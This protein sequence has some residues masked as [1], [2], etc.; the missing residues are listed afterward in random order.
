MTTIQQ[1]TVQQLLLQIDNVAGDRLPLISWTLTPVTF[2]HGPAELFDMSAT[3]FPRYPVAVPAACFAT[4]EIKT[5]LNLTF[6]NR[7]P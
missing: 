1:W 5:I 4:H 7:K 3:A 6:L 2:V